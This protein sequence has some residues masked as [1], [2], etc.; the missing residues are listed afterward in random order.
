M[1]KTWFWVA[2]AIFLSVVLVYHY[3]KTDNDETN[4][5]DL[6]KPK[7]PD[8]KIDFTKQRF[9]LDPNYVDPAQKTFDDYLQE[10]FFS[11]TP[12]PQIDSEAQ[13]IKRVMHGQT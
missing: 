12:T 10:E 1:D 11:A 6:L 9:K 13:R 4:Q 5:E 2:F 3:D 7:L 8:Y